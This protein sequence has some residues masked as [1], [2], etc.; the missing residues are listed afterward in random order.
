[1][2]NEKLNLLKGL[3]CVCVVFIHI[4]F[5]GRF[6]EIV[7]EVSSFAVPVFYMTAGYYSLNKNPERIKKNLHNIIWIF[8]YAYTVFFVYRVG[9]ALLNNQV[10]EWI[11][12]NYNYKTP[13]KYIC[14]C[15]I[16]FAIPLWYLIG[17]IETYC[18]WLIIVK[19]QKEDMAIKYFY[20]LF[21][22]QFTLVTIC[23][24]FGVAWFWRINFLTCSLPWFLLG[25]CFHT[26]KIKWIRQFGVIPLI[27]VALSGLAISILPLIINTPIKF[28][29]VG[30]FLYAFAL[31]ALTQVDSKIICNKALCKQ[32]QFIGENLTLNI[33]IFHVLIG[34]VVSKVGKIFN[35]GGG[36]AWI[37]PLIVIMISIMWAYILLKLKERVMGKHKH[38]A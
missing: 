25:Y 14:F 1:M 30:R 26:D 13:I 5:P 29:I 21:L 6:G 16:D 7:V 31:F 18:A 28:N 23:D 8:F 19:H 35:L 22:I 36:F 15:T 38:E 4:H 34:E 24:S 17:M 37:E 3:A 9:I 2:K 11:K 10:F 32:I 27:F 33:Y 20:I 12:D